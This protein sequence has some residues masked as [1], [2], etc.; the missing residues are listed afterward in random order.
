VTRTFTDEF[1][2]VLYSEPMARM[3]Y[4]DAVSNGTCRLL[5]DGVVHRP[6]RYGLGDFR[7]DGAPWFS[8]PGPLD[9]QL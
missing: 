9:A 8:D 6:I 1:F 3:V 7:C 4:L 2:S 5:R